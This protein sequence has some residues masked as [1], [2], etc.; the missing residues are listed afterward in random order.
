MKSCEICEKPHERAAR[1]CSTECG[2]KLR[3]Q[4]MKKSYAESGS[5]VTATCARLECG[6]EFQHRRS[7]PQR[8]CSKTCYNQMAHEA[9]V[10]SRT[11]GE[12]G[13]PMTAFKRQDQQFCSTVCRNRN[14]AAKRTKNYPTCQ[15]CG[16]STGS[17]NRIFCDDHRPK[18]GRAAQPRKVAVCLGCGEEFSRPAHWQ[19]K[20]KYCS[21]ACSHRQVKKVR[22]KF[23]ADLPE[24][25]VVFHSGWEIRFWAACLRFDIPIRSYDGPDIK[26]SEGVYRPDFIIG[27][28]GEERVVDVKGWLRPESEVKC[29]EAGVHLVTKQELLRLESGDSLDAHRMLVWNSGMNAHTAVL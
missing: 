13:K 23:I 10:V 22:D 2:K 25:A 19:G 20:L 15:I 29:R 16:V 4:A 14:T 18:P 5:W 1:T 21:N 28:P 7:K 24:G 26:T 9:A 3:A 27:K 12:C 11:C 8:F 6:Q 17:Y